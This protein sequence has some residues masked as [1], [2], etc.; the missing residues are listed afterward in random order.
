MRKTSVTLVALAATVFSLGAN[1]AT[2][3]YEGSNLNSS[4]GFSF[5]NLY[6]HSR[7][8]K[9]VFETGLN[10]PI[11]TLKK[12]SI[13]FPDAPDL[14]VSGFKSNENDPRHF[15]AIVKNA[16]VFKEVRVEVFANVERQVDDLQIRISVPDFKSN[17]QDESTADFGTE[18]VNISGPIFDVSPKRNV[19][20]ASFRR[21]GKRVLLRLKDRPNTSGP[22]TE[23][24]GSGF[25][26]EVDW[27][28]FGKRT[29]YLPT[30]FQENEFHR[31]TA[32]GLILEE[33]NYGTETMHQISVRYVD[34][35]NHTQIGNPIELETLL[36]DSYDSF[37]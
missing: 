19:D 24:P 3:T 12:L 1:A 27:S 2:Y 14:A 37:E 25:E 8:A 15:T 34:E 33:Q 13:E 30:P 36:R 10:T 29:L 22:Y 9:L 32:V 18:L 31:F 16:W 11:P 6:L 20:S 28:G 4:S 17:T 35:F 26:V 21:D 23:M 7:N 5:P